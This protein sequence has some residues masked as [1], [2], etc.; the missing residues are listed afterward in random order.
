MHIRLMLDRLQEN[1]RDYREIFLTAPGISDYLSGCI[2][3]K[4]TLC[5]STAD[6]TP[7]VEVLRQAG[8]LVGIKVDE[9]CITLACKSSKASQNFSSVHVR[10]VAVKQGLEALKNSDGESHTRGLQ[11]L[12]RNCRE[13]AR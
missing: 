3:Y 4:E 9:V 12:S 10:G 6:G 5:Q 2:L 7:F 1:R 13:Y 8:I 11:N